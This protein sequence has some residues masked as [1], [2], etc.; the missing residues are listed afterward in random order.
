MD[1][2]IYVNS[3]FVYEE[4]HIRTQ[5]K[6]L[7]LNVLVRRCKLERQSLLNSLVIATLAPDQFAYNLMKGPGYM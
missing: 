1:L 6:Q 2:F 5:I 3:K 4:R 7:Y